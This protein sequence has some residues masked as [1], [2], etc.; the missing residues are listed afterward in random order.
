MQICKPNETG[1]HSDRRGATA[2]LKKT[3]PSTKFFKISHN[4]LQAHAKIRYYRRAFYRHALCTGETDSIALVA[5][6]EWST[7]EQSILARSDVCSCILTR[8]E[9]NGN[10]HHLTRALIP[11]LVSFLC[12]SSCCLALLCPSMYKSDP[13]T[14]LSTAL[15][16]L[17]NASSTDAVPQ[18]EV[19][20]APRL[21]GHHRGP[22]EWSRNHRR[23]HEK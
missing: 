23:S 2:P 9:K 13:E 7:L 5:V 4:T 8:V 6:L 21:G 16:M 18:L 15:A 3:N 20:P 11:K 1:M 17:Q 10:L 14:K 22:I 12:G 19:V